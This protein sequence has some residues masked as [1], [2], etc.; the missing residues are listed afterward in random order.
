MI[1]SSL[2]LLHH[3]KNRHKC[4]RGDRCS[5]HAGHIG[6]HGV[7]QQEV[8]RIRLRPNLLRDSGSH[9]YRRYT[10]GTD[11]WIHFSVSNDAHQFPKKDSACRTKSEGDQTQD[12][13]LNGIHIQE[14][15]RACGSSYRCSKQNDYNIHQRVGSG[16]HKLSYHS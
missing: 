7:H 13:D 5:D 9:R 2:I 6:A 14:R 8:R 11:Q 12:H 15:F 3:S 16:I 1:S 4:S 10:C